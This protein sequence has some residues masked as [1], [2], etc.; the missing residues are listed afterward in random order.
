MTLVGFFPLALVQ[1]MTLV[2]QV[3]F[4]FRSWYHGGKPH[5]RFCVVCEMFLQQ[6][7]IKL[8]GITVGCS[9]HVE[10]NSSSIILPLAGTTRFSVG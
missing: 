9:L 10:E 7:L 3:D 4:M 8:Q 1:S 5:L 2:I 6:N